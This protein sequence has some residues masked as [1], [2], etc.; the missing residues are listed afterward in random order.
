[1]DRF[2]IIFN[3]QFLAKL[4]E[5]ETDERRYLWYSKYKKEFWSQAI[6]NMILNET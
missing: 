4:S 1:M 2:K 6:Y 5:N 3:F